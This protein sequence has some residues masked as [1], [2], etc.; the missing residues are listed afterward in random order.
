MEP[1]VLVG[2]RLTEEDLH[3]LDRM[4]RSWGKGTRSDVLREL[5]HLAESR[6][7]AGEAQPEI[8][9]NLLASLERLVE[10]G[11][12]VDLSGALTL[13]LVRGFEKLR[14]DYA[15]IAEAGRQSADAIHSERQARRKSTEAGARFLRGKE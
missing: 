11:W 13:A 1:K 7:P 14:E 10:N 5:I 2:V 9:P 8:P 6:W 3:S 12:A 4:S 15:T